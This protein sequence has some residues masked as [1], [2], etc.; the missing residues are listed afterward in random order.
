[1]VVEGNKVTKKGDS[2][3]V[4]VLGA[5][6]LILYPSPRIRLGKITGR[7]FAYGVADP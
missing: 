1:M 6:P 4:R 5:I 3:S 7:H 2:Y